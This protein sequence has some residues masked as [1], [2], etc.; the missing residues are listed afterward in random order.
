MSDPLVT[1]PIV[2]PPPPAP[3]VPAR[4]RTGVVAGAVVVALALVAGAVA[5]VLLRDGSSAQARPLALRFTEGQSETYTIHQTMQGQVGSDMAG[6]ATMSF[7]MPMDMDM[8]Q[9]LTWEVTSVDDDGV[10]TVQVG[11]SEMSGSV[12][13]MEMPASAGT[14]P[15]VEIQIAP[16]GRVV[17][18]GGFALGGAGQTQGFGF[19]GMSQLT[20]ILPDD[21]EAV[22]PGDSWDK[23]FSQDFP[24]GDGTIS[25]TASSTYD[26]NES[27]GGREAA[28]IV[29]HMSVPMDFT[30]DFA[31]ML[32]AFGDDLGAAGATGLDQLAGASIAYS[33][34]GD[35]TQTSFVDLQA[36]E[37]LRSES[38]GEF[39][40]A[41]EYGGMPGFEGTMSFVGTFTQEVEVG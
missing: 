7:D 8:T 16:D 17:S 18:A 3:E 24:F 19:P 33:G 35:I 10:A 21:G 6:D 4:R 11:V 27:V 28:V 36:E 2:P 29:T 25:Y 1:D 39:D 37:L 15:P 32:D 31:E 40:I 14:V 12:N 22:A 38:S 26:R 13:G 34:Q 41:M 30:M 9:V 5:F 23:E 20:P